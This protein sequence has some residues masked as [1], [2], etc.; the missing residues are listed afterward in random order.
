[1]ASSP[2]HAACREPP[3]HRV[4]GAGTRWRPTLPRGWENTCRGPPPPERVPHLS[5]PAYPMA[6][7]RNAHRRPRGEDAPAGEGGIGEPPARVRGRFWSGGRWLGDPGPTRFAA[8]PNVVSDDGDDG[9]PSDHHAGDQR[10]ARHGQVLDAHSRSPSVRGRGA[11]HTTLPVVQR[12][13]ADGA[14]RRHVDEEGGAARPH[15]SSPR[16]G[17]P[18]APSIHR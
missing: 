8:E 14:R 12:P 1:M 11:L 6:G 7:A 17:A 10:A 13:L 3:L 2:G 9:D 15:S 16:R 4:R 18:P 5:S